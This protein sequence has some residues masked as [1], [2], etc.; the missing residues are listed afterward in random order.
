MN[1]TKKAIITSQAEWDKVYQSTLGRDGFPSRHICGLPVL[2]LEADNPSYPHGSRDP[3]LFIFIDANDI[4]QLLD[5]DRRIKD[6]D[7]AGCQS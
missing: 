2:V 5:I 6:R 1:F 4:A 7:R 3:K